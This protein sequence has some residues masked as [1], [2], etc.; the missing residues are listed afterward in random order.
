MTYFL[1][2]VYFAILTG[3]AAVLGLVYAWF[4]PGSS[5]LFNVAVGT[6]GLASMVIMLVYS[7]ARRSKL[8]RSWARL[9]TWLHLHIFLGLQGILLVFFHCTP[10]LYREGHAALLNPGVL[11][12]LAVA[13]VF[14][15]GLFGRYLYAQVPKTLG[16]QHLAISALEEELAAVA[17]VPKEVHALWAHAPSHGGVFAIVGSDLQRRSA[18]RRLRAMSLPPDVHALAARRVTLEWQKSVLGGAQGIFRLW[19]LLHRP[20]AIAMYFLSAVHMALAFMFTP[21]LRFW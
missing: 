11:N 12:L 15:S 18:L 7:I 3:E 16:G 2:A 21:S 6:I 9:S 8:L 13:V 20:L 10:M 1:P 4:Q 17:D 19:I 5:S 14:F